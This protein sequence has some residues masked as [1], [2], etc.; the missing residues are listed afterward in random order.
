MFDTYQIIGK[1]LVSYAQNRHKLKYSINLFINY[2][3]MLLTVNLVDMYVQQNP[4][5]KIQ[6][7][8][9]NYV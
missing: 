4:N 6:N 9:A 5:S 3:E 7:F 1:R 2:V 8:S